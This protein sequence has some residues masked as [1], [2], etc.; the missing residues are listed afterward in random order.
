MSD[1]H[2]CNVVG[3]S[4]LS[5]VTTC[6]G[7]CFFLF[8][9]VR[10]GQRSAKRFAVVCVVFSALETIPIFQKAGGIALS[11]LMRLRRSFVVALVPR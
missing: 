5:I 8:G 7:E 11:L 2:R 10:E 9:S 3:E 6:R 4:Q 1:C